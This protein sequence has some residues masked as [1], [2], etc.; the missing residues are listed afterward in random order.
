[1]GSDG[2]IGGAGAADG[3]I[4]GPCHRV[5]RLKSQ[6]CGG[7]RGVALFLVLLQH[8][9]VGRQGPGALYKEFS[10]PHILL[11]IHQ[12]DLVRS[13][14]EV[15]HK[16]FIAN[17]GSIDQLHG[18]PP[19]HR[20]II[21]PDLVAIGIDSALVLLY[22][23]LGKGHAHGLFKQNRAVHIEIP[24]CRVG[25]FA[26]QVILQ[27]QR[28]KTGLLYGKFPGQLQEFL[29]PAA[30]FFSLQLRLLTGR[31]KLRRQANV[32]GRILLGQCLPIG[33][34]GDILLYTLRQRAGFSA[35]LLRQRDILNL[36][37]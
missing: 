26:V 5:L 16:G 20:H 17:T 18:L 6:L 9:F 29:R 15:E 31:Q 10:H 23:A 32:I 14:L 8:F 28:I 34:I 7:N 2:D 3:N 1:M 37:S 27:S 12:G 35:E 25:L 22:V 33:L 19:I 13:R 30:G 21:A 24:L 11:F 36:C 4:V